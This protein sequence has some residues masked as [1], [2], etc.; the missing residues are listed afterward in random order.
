MV[1][2][3]GQPVGRLMTDVRDRRVA[4]V[5]IAILPSAQGR[6]LATRLMLRALEEPRRL[7][8]P[9]RVCVLAQNVAS[10]KL[11][12]RL[13]FVRLEEVSPFVWLEW[14]G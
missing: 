2:F 8:L 1:E 9:A 11:C 13:G 4:Y 12:E 14:R 3:E 6:G 7:G 5:D 10:L